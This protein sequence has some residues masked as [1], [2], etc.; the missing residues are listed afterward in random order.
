[1]NLYVYVFLPFT[2]SQPFLEA[3]VTKSKACEHR[4]LESLNDLSETTW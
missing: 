4:D 3:D 1:M 2:N